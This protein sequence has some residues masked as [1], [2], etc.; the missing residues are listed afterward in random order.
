[1]IPLQLG[2]NG[3]GIGA[4]YALVA[5]GFALIFGTTRI[6]HVS[7]G[8]T[9]L[10]CEYVFWYLTQRVHWPVAA[11]VVTC[12]VV[13][14]AFGTAL[15]LLLYQPMRRRG[16]QSFFAMFVGSLGALI[17]IQN[18][19]VMIFGSDAQEV[20]SSIVQG[21]QVGGLVIAPITYIE[22]GVGLVLFAGVLVVMYGTRIGSGLRATASDPE[23]M[24]SVGVGRRRYDIIAFIIGSMLV[25]PAAIMNLYVNGVSPSDG[26]SISLIAFT[27]TIVGGVGSIVG[28]SVGALLIGIVEN[29]S[30]WKI[31]GVWSQGIV[32]G[33]LVVFLVA[34]PS[35][36]LRATR[37]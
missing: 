10:I 11:A 9:F 19:I 15:Y 6:F 23:L 34:R 1:L 36:L 26:V 8:A 35:G 37:A 17:A 14:A 24:D 22:F 31:S 32:F 3:I 21:H 29:V 28:A 2:I 25:A 4:V 30:V 7:H 27:A 13:A 33:L 5:V 20:P 18:I 16:R 12:V